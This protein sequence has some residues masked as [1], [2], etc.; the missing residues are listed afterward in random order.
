V[1]QGT[2]RH[3]AAT[4]RAASPVVPRE[5]RLTSAPSHRN[6]RANIHHDRASRPMN[7]M[8]PAGS[9]IS[10]STESSDPVITIPAGSGGAMRFFGAA[11]LVFWLGGW[12]V[13]FAS[14]GHQVLSGTPS[15]FIIFWLCAWTIGGG[16]AVVYL[17]RLLR[18]SVPETLRLGI[19]SVAYDSG[20][21]PFRNNYYGY[22]ARPS[23]WR[24]DAWASLFPKRTVVT[25]DRRQMQ[26]LR[27]RDTETDNRLTVDAGAE[28]L[29]L[30]RDASEVE[31]EWLYRVLAE[32]YGVSA[33]TTDGLGR[34][35][36]R[37]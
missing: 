11:F 25:I 27:L 12:T 30:A 26:T 15:P 3:C 31:R 18:P 1:K 14:A 10:V 20:I 16:F 9:T 7:L 33:E 5:R 37:R 4:S 17:Y 13:G 34:T 24:K 32:K 8:P 21:P 2:A 23:G 22:G 19:S 28:R 29:D 36:E 35:R 6:L